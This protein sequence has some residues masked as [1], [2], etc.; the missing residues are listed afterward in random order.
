[1]HEKIILLASKS[2]R[3]K[4]LLESLG[5]KVK[6]IE[7]DVEEDYPDSLK[8]HEVAEF[9]AKKKAAP[10]TMSM[11]ENHYLITADS[12]VVLDD[13]IYGKPI[14]RQDAYNTLK[15]LSGNVHLVYTG[16]CI[17]SRKAEISFTE[18]SE[19]KFATLSDEEIYFYLD[20]F[21]PYDKAGSYGIQDWIGL[22]KVEWIKG[23]MS[24]IMGLPTAETYKWLN[25]I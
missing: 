13:V 6:L 4:Q 10:Y 21:E 1:M 24:N 5:L 25:Q 23:T 2:P 9:L 15:K 12:I 16:V 18:K 11:E 20:K 22:A 3:R 7:I 14:D 8:T 17:K 19:I